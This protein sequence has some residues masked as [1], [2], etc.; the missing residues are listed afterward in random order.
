MSSQAD[1]AN[2]YH[3]VSSFRPLAR[4]KAFAATARPR[5]ASI[6]QTFSAGGTRGALGEA[7][8][9]RIRVDERAQLDWSGS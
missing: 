8:R 3:P 2:F 1:L 6:G 4:S 9:L 7:V 5:R